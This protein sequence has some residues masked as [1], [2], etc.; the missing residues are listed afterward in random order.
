MKKKIYMAAL[1]FM[2]LLLCVPVKVQACA[3]EEY[4]AEDMGYLKSCI[5]D[6]IA[7]QVRGKAS[8]LL[9]EAAK[10]SADEPVYRSNLA[11]FDKNE[12]VSIAKPFV[13]WNAGNDYEVFYHFPLVQNEKVIGVIA[14]SDIYP[15]GDSFLKG[16]PEFWLED[17][18]ADGLNDI[19]YLKSE[20]VLYY[21]KGKT[22]AENS[23]KNVE[24]ASYSGYAVNGAADM[25]N[26][27][28]H[29]SFSEKKKAL[30]S[31]IKEIEGEYEKETVFPWEM[32]IVILLFLFSIV[33]I[34]RVRKR[35]F[36][37]KFS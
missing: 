16:E 36:S 17:D 32:A 3:V 1:L 20:F 12:P 21:Y 31:R 18:L 35:K 6:K 19:D 8:E 29:K 15:A 27:F 26:E 5:P 13:I 14:G 30:I 37:R 9:D 11:Q 22:F 34:N 7:G 4:S 33:T 23:E 10:A 24:V 25:E 28:Y 2:F